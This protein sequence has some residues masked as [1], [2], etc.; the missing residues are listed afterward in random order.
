MALVYDPQKICT[1]ASSHTNKLNNIVVMGC[2]VKTKKKKVMKM[3]LTS[4][5]D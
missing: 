3:R 4:I 1:Q 2:F 5:N